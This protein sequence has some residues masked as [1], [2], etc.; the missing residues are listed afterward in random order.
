MM[1]KLDLGNVVSHGIELQDFTYLVCFV[2]LFGLFFK[3][4]CTFQWENLAELR[5]L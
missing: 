3:F 4:K 1:L 5:I 2:Q